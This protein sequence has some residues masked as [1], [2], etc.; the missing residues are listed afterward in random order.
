VPPDGA[1]IRR[2]LQAVDADRLDAAVDQ[3]CGVVLGQVWVDG[4][5]NEIT[6]FAPLLE[7]FWPGCEL[8]V[9]KSQV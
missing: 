2:V 9:L 3:R 6:R 1:T 8:D 5:I 7:P 4:K